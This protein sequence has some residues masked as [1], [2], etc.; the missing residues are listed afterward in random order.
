MFC[1]KCGNV[2]STNAS[3]CK[4]CGNAVRQ[5]ATTDM[6]NSGKEKRAP[7]VSARQKKTRRPKKTAVLA[8][9]AVFVIGFGAYFIW[10]Y[11]R[12]KSSVSIDF[13][14][15]TYEVIG[16]IN[17]VDAIFYAENKV[18]Y[19]SGAINVDAKKIKSM[20]I[21]TAVGK[22]RLGGG[23]LRLSS[24]TAPNT[25]H[26]RYN[27]PI[28]L[29]SYNT[30]TVSAVLT[31][32]NIITNTL[33]LVSESN[34]N[35]ENFELDTGDNDGDGLLNWQELAL[36]TDP[37][38]PDTDDDGL[39][40][41][42]E[43]YITFSNPLLYDTYSLG[44]SDADA[45][46]DDDGISNIDEIRIYGTDP[47]SSDTDGDWLSDYDEIFVY[48]TNPL[49]LDTDGDGAE[50]GWEVWHGFDPLVFNRSF[51]HTVSY[52]EPNQLFPVTASVTVDLNG[53]QVESLSIRTVKP[54]ENWMLAPTIPGYLGVAYDFSVD[55][56]FRTAE[57]TFQYDESLGTIGSDF[58]PRIYYYDEN[59]GD[60]LELPKQNVEN[61]RVTV[62]VSHFSKYILL[63]K[64][65]FDAVWDIDIR[66][67]RRGDDTSPID[68]IL[69]IDESNS[70]R[71][72]DSGDIRVLASRQIASSLFEGD[73]VGVIGFDSR[74]RLLSELTDDMDAARAAISKISISGGTAMYAGLAM[75]LDEF[76]NNSR[77]NSR[78]III[79]LTDGEDYPQNPDAYDSII[80]EAKNKSVVI[81][82]IG[83]GNSLNELLLDSI[84]QKTGGAYFHATLAEE[85]YQGFEF[86]GSQAIEEM[87]DSN[88]DGIPDYFSRLIFEGKLRLQNGSAEL[89][90]TDF[91]SDPDIDGDGLLNG[92]EIEIVRRGDRI[93]VKLLSHPLLPDSDFD[94]K[95]DY[96]EI[97]NGTRP[98]FPDF[99][100]LA[101]IDNLMRSSD[102]EYIKYAHG[103]DPSG[104]E[105]FWNAFIS[106]L[107]GVSVQQS[108]TFELAEFFARTIDQEYLEHMMM[109]ETK[110]DLINKA[111]ESIADHIEE[112]DSEIE[113]NGY[114]DSIAAELGIRIREELTALHSAIELAAS[115]GD[116]ESMKELVI[117]YAFKNREQ[118]EF[119][120]SDF[121]TGALLTLDILGIPGDFVNFVQYKSGGPAGTGTMDGVGAIV[122]TITTSLEFALDLIEI[123][124]DSQT[125]WGYYKAFAHDKATGKII[126]RN[127]DILVELSRSNRP[128]TRQAAKF[129]LNSYNKELGSA[130]DLQVEIA[131]IQGISAAIDLAKGALGVASIL[132][133]PLMVITLPL[134]VLDGLNTVFGWSANVETRAQFF[135]LSDMAY[136]TNRLVG[137]VYLKDEAALYRHLTNLVNLHIT[138]ETRFSALQGVGAGNARQNI[139]S[140]ETLAKNRGLPIFPDGRR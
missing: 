138:G 12:S 25:S 136:A 101:D 108:Y 60:L 126:D 89:M 45:D 58:Q 116:I 86:I 134:T 16:I 39:T 14:T 19:I 139:T 114:N 15:S 70:M 130:V 36:G 110:V 80:D 72:N 42:E 102:F 43:I 23:E 68:L 93:Y 88:G 48:G 121:V 55:G 99:F 41:W 118:I 53:A 131:A 107:A 97:Q 10:G 125:M 69:V 4:R 103:Y 111:W 95:N 65:D 100:D 61:G 56:D 46:F 2:L 20:S 84:A 1:V 71:D 115:T 34:E 73:R 90:G 47:L 87:E 122:G 30:I 120:R 94:G 104:F 62:T 3:F 128:E 117:K 9:I 64:I 11:F 24:S 123:V 57:M 77:P 6:T 27:N 13:N 5:R 113:Q 78:K 63:N 85:I 51:N 133:P 21:S 7:R 38:N 31:N 54:S 67:P 92:E 32:G 112:A 79:A 49:N 26:W 74:A 105:S 135:V 91:D 127:L 132:Y 75:A 66:A 18:D 98:L 109:L 17:D 35:H 96:E 119:M 28:L 129:L 29:P 83:L 124:N 22:L 50:D 44:I 40:D 59:T 82:T 140:I 106:T 81:Y 8:V 33:Q 76:Q 52:G 37:N 137:R